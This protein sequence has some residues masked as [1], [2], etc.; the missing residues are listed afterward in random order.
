MKYLRTFHYKKWEGIHDYKIIDP[1][2]HANIYQSTNDVVPSSLKIAAIQQ[3]YI[4][5]T[6][7]NEL[8]QQLERIENEHRHSIRQGYTQMQAAVPTTFGRLL[9]SYNEALSRDWWRVSKCV[10]RLK[11][12]NLGGGAVGTGLAIPRFFIMEVTRNLRDIT[13]LPLA[14]SENLADTTSNMD[15]FTEVHATLK[16]LAVNLEKMSNDIRLLSSDI[17]QR[18]EMTIPSCQTGS[19]IMPGKV[20][21]VIVEYVISVAHSVYANDVLVS[22]LCGAGCLELNAYVPT[23]GHRLLESIELLTSACKSMNDN[24]IKGLEIN[25]EKALQSVLSSPTIAIA[26]VPI[27]GYNKATNLNNY[28]KA[29]GLDI[30][31]ATKELGIIPENQLKELLKSENLTKE[32]FNLEDIIQ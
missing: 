14:R 18:K 26:L 7:I 19:T 31:E 24:L 6:T 27:I 3:L 9:G 4:L 21:P 13:R 22:S 11:Q 16:A 29:T 1:I 2:E 30:F 32:G 20:N 5:E 10:E 17:V 28:M 15:C 8:R 12:L 25:T 23:I